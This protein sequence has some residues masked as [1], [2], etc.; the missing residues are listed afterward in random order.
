MSVDLRTLQFKCPF[1]SLIAGP[2]GAGKTVLVRR[3]LKNH[4]LLFD[5]NAP[6]L[7]VLWLYGVYQKAFNESISA[8]EIIYREGLPEEAEIFENKPHLIVIDDLMIEL[9]AN[10][11]LTNLFTKHSH[12]HN[13]SIF[14]LTQN[15]FYQGSQM[16]TI[17]LN[18]HYLI[19]LKNPRDKMQINHL[20][21][22]LFPDKP[23]LVLEAYEDATRSNYGY[24]LI[25]LKPDTPEA[26]R[27]RTRITLEER[28]PFSPIVYFRK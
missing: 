13:I 10:K 1:T 2:T 12:H 5:L 24:L 18:S 3:I 15:F 11:K 16:R 23:K 4:K 25:D 9:G 7:K 19:L 14:F 27:L 20:A 26:F 21:K 17:S 28:S 22:Q 6:I 8:V